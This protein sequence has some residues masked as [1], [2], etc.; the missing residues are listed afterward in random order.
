M[1]G[2]VTGAAGTIGQVLMKG[3]AKDHGIVGIDCRDAPGVTVLDLA[4]PNKATRDRLM[5]LFGDAEFV[6]HL[7]WDTREG[8]TKLHEVFTDSETG[9]AHDDNRV[10]G[11]HVLWAAHRAKVRRFIF[12]SSV[13]AMLGHIPSYKYPESLTDRKRHE[14][15][16]RPKI[17]ARKP[18]KPSGGVY[19]ASK[20]Y[21]EALGYSFA[22]TYGMEFIAIRFGNVR[23]DDSPKRSEYPFYISHRDCVQFVELCLM[24]PIWTQ[25]EQVHHWICTAV[26]EDKCC[27]FSLNDERYYLGYGPQD[28]T[29]CPFNMVQ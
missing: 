4:D 18:P 23:K 13:H 9:I 12:A 1:K 17:A 11:E 2:I 24:T 14:M 29:P 25:P 15:L 20:I 10:M 22:Q 21:F 3:L 19:G 5:E 6:I 27:P 16:H 7:A 8:G 26:S 28:G